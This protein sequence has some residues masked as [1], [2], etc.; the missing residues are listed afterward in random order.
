MQP[1]SYNCLTESKEWLVIPGE[2]CALD[3]AAFNSGMS[4]SAVR[5]DSMVAPLGRRTIK[6][7]PDLTLFNHGALIYRKLPVHPDST[8]AVSCGLRRGEARKN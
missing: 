5:E 8:I 2:I 3:A 4:N 6:G 7:V 1:S